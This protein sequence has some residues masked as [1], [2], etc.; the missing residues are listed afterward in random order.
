MY[1][2]F[3]DEVIVL[4]RNFVGEKDLVLTVYTKKLGKESI[5]IPNGQLIKNLPFVYLAEFVWFNGVFYKIKDRLYISEIDRFK[6]MGI[7]LA[8][9]Y[10][11]FVSGYNIINLIYKYAPHQDEKI[12]ILFK[13]SIYYLTVAKDVKVFEL[14][15][16]I[17]LIYLNGE[18]N[19]SKMEITDSEKK[20]LNLL[21]KLNLSQIALNL[22]FSQKLDLEYLK[23]K[24]LEFL[25]M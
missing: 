12:F 9:D 11:K 14:A 25:N 21:M 16:L 2:F 8:K 17:R 13:K 24:L 18:L 1:T 7:D 10:K 20:F 6:N 4:R 19:I 5:F 22:D 23:N 3:K 15:F